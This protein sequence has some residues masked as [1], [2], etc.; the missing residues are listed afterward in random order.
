MTA[1]LSY[2]PIQTSY[3]AQ[4]M[5]EGFIYIPLEGGPGRKIQDILLPG[6]NLTCQWLLDPVEYTR[7][8]G[9]FV[10]TLRQGQD[11]FL[12]DLITDIGEPTTHLCRTIGGL[13]RLTQQKAEGYWVTCNIEAD[14]NPTFTDTITYSLNDG[15]SWAFDGIDD[16]IDLG[17]VL[18]FSRTSPFS[19]FFWYRTSVSDRC[20][21]GK[22]SAANNQ[23]FRFVVRSST[24]S[25]SNQDFIFA[26][27]SAIQQ[28]QVG[29]TPRPPID[30]QLHHF[31]ITY[32]GSSTSS[33]FTFYIDGDVCVTNSGTDNLTSASTDTAAPF[34]IGNRGTTGVPSNLP[35][36][37]TIEHVSVWNAEL[38]AS[39][40]DEVYN[41]GNF[42]NLSTTSM[43]A[44]LVLWM[45]INTSDATGA[46]GVTDYSN[47]GFDG[48]AQNGLGSTG[49]LVGKVSAA[50][51]ARFFKSGDKLRILYSAGIHPDGNIP[52]NLDG[53]YDVV[54][55]AG[56]GVVLLDQPFITNPDWNVLYA[57]DPAAEYGNPA[58]GD[59]T[60]TITRV[61]S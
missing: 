32:D 23:G 8:M 19:I 24:G 26:G 20:A 55:N 61:P 56:T 45:Q 15:E 49:A 37:G 22:Q 60:S 51:I 34:K 41:N 9:F 44:N 58:D 42:P 47:S 18:D 40:V 33:G 13:P 12:L 14:K 53:I 31:G 10:T 1:I 52:L 5:E 7:F 4:E 35:F 27:P 28:I 30:G 57:I 29:C 11:D 17:D 6:H 50:G 38:T 39:Q 3:T 46:N 21:I 36:E 2:T 59:V 48:T 25:G 16:E 54:G 43:V